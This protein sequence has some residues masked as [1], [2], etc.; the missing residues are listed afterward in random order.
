MG[1]NILFSI[2]WILLL[3]FIAWPVAAFLAGIWIIL[4]VRM[5]LWSTEDHRSSQLADALFAFHFLAVRCSLFATHCN[6]RWL[7]TVPCSH[8]LTT[9]PQ[10]FEAIFAFVKTINNF[11]EKL[12]TWPR[13]LGRAIMNCQES[14]PS[15]M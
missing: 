2:I 9:T 1:K 3:F 12:I 8:P 11:L 7:A 10:P 15:P 13:D 6:C 4:Q 14:F 5:L